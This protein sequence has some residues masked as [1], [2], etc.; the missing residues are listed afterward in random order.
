MKEREREREREELGVVL[1]A[2]RKKKKNS[3]GF[4]IFRAI[5][6]IFPPFV[7]VVVSLFRFFLSPTPFPTPFCFSGCSLF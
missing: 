1:D 6:L 3:S 5:T 4:P 7:V 2:D